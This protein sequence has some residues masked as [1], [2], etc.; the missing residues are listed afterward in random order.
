[1]KRVRMHRSEYRRGGRLWGVAVLCLALVAPSLIASERKPVLFVGK[2]PADV[3]RI[4][5]Q[6]RR[7]V[8]TATVLACTS[9]RVAATK[10]SV[11]EDLMRGRSTLPE[12]I[13][14]REE[15]VHTRMAMLTVR[16]RRRDRETD[17]L[18]ISRG[19]VAMIKEDGTWRI[20]HE[21]WK[22]VGREDIP[23]D[24]RRGGGRP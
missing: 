17:A 19:E 20:R 13:D 12:A 9:R 8:D 4:V 1:M 23:L 21:V 5:H 2:S 6:A 7:N 24:S 3:Y 16:G 22:D 10:G 15:Q 14:V 18:I 11:Y